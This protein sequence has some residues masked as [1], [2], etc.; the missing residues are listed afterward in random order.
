[1]IDDWDSV[2]LWQWDVVDQVSADGVG[3]RD[4][5]D[6]VDARDQP[7]SVT[8]F[9]LDCHELDATVDTRRFG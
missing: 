4:R 9:V 2:F 6:L 8:G 7:R 1:M 3:D 5:L